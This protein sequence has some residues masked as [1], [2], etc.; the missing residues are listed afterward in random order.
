MST[1][2]IKTTLVYKTSCTQCTECLLSKIKITILQILH[3]VIKRILLFS[4]LE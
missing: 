4:L 1:F 2:S 3:R